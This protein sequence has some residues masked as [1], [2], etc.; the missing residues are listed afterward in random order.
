[1][2]YGKAIRVVRTAYGLTQ[3]ELAERLSIGSSQLSLIESGRR[4]PSLKVLDEVS[5]AL[6]VPPH[7]LTLLASDPEDVEDKKN[8]SEIAELAR[9]LLKLLVSAGRQ[10]TLPLKRKKPA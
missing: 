8:G 2:D 4:K 9:S 1:M 7:L 5:S 3:T 10:P 6:R